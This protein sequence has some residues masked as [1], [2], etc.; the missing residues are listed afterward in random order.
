MVTAIKDWAEGR[1]RDW[2]IEEYEPGKKNLT[3]IYSEPLLEELISYNDKGNFDRVMA[4]FCVMIYMEELH[5]LHVKKK[6]DKDNVRRLFLE[7]LFQEPF[8]EYFN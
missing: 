3:K 6:E 2:L 7:P 4:M 5:D 8:L 1:L